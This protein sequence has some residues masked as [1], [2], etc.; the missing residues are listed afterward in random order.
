MLIVS[1]IFSVSLHTQTIVLI[2]YMFKIPIY[3]VLGTS[4][5]FALVVSIIDIIN[6]AFHLIQNRESKPFI[7]SSKQVI[8]S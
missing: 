7:N 5:S 4:V 1:S 6:T 2:N 8:M 3:S